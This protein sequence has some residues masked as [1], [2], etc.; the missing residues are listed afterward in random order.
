MVTNHLL[1][2]M[3]LQADPQLPVYE[4]NPFHIWGTWS[5]PSMRPL[6][7]SGDVEKKSPQDDCWKF[8]FP[9]KVVK[10]FLGKAFQS[11][12]TW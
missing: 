10:S 6:N 2:G 5:N 8:M 9:E 4:G 1:T 7:P 11:Q 12:S 3:I